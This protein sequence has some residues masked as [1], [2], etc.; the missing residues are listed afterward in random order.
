[1]SKT[2]QES[3]PKR[4]F[5]NDW[6]EL[7]KLPDGMPKKDFPFVLMRL[8]REFFTVTRNVFVVARENRYVDDGH[9]KDIIRIGTVVWARN[10]HIAR[11]VGGLLSSINQR[12][13]A[14]GNDTPPAELLLGFARSW[15]HKDTYTAARKQ[16]HGAVEHA[17]YD[18][19]GKFKYKVVSLLPFQVHYAKRSKD[20]NEIPI[21]I[22]ILLGSS[23]AKRINQQLTPQKRRTKK[24][25]RKKK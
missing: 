17:T 11:V 25:A 19:D 20:D 21:A 15:K 3:P 4:R 14:I 7:L 23:W 2:K 8:D 16:G 1:M 13:A 6:G 18:G 5:E 9:R 12:K 24:K 22:S 10:E